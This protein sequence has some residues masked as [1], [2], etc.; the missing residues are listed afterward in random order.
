MKKITILII[1]F[2][3]CS[4]KPTKEGLCGYQ[5][6]NFKLILNITTS[7]I[8][9]EDHYVYADSLSDNCNDS[10]MLVETV[11]RYLQ[12]AK[13]QY[14]IRSV[15]FLT[16]TSDFDMGETISQ[17]WPEINKNCILNVYFDDAMKIKEFNFFDNQGQYCYQGPAWRP[18][19]QI[20]PYVTNLSEK[21][22]YYNN[23]TVHHQRGN[24]R[25]VN[26]Y[27][28]YGLQWQNP[29][30]GE[31]QGWEGYQG[32]QFQDEEWGEDGGLELYDFHARM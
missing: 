32:K 2:L 16:D 21:K 28:P 25:Q 12:N 11:Y 30:L 23:L 10:A 6:T 14:H 13:H 26:E 31:G 19:K 27:Y 4:S 5:Q 18:C 15:N 1:V 22:V 17:N 24:I 9:E 3:S 7:M 29:S 20:L 8:N